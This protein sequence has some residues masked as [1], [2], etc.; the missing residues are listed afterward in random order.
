[1]EQISI[2]KIGGVLYLYV[3]QFLS[4]EMVRLHASRGHI[5]L[6]INVTSIDVASYL[7]EC[8]ATLNFAAKRADAIM[9]SAELAVK[10]EQRVLSYLR[11]VTCTNTAIIDGRVEANIQRNRS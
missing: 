9:Q 6:F 11:L 4:I 7:R 2:A 3:E 1:M 8:G 5:S 10:A